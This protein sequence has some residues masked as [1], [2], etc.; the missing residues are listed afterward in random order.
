M[1]NP[2]VFLGIHSPFIPINPVLDG[3]AISAGYEY[4]FEVELEREENL[5]PP[6][7]QTNCQDNGPSKDAKNFTN[8][9]SYEMCLGM[10]ESESSE[11]LYDCKGGWTMIFLSRKFC[12]PSIEKVNMISNRE[13]EIEERLVTCFQNCKPGC[14]QTL[15]VKYL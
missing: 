7:Y 11:A 13:L 9:N 10:C 4:A 14:L 1:D 8:P 2:Q 6:P 12:I 3:Y 15:L 5:L